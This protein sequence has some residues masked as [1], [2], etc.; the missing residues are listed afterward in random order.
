MLREGTDISIGLNIDTFTPADSQEL[1]E[2]LRAETDL[3]VAS[4]I[5]AADTAPGG[6]LP[7]DVLIYILHTLIPVAD[8]YASVIASAIW[9]RV[10][11]ALARQGK[12]EAGVTF[13]LVE[14]DDDGN[15]RRELRGETRNQEVI[16]ELIRQFGKDQQ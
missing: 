12:D 15:M 11:A 10:K 9:D 1:V 13:S 14:A 2:R 16:K 5:V 6:P 3:R 4:G 8:I 7:P